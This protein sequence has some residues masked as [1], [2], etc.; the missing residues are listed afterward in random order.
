MMYHSNTDGTVS[1]LAGYGGEMPWSI[2]RS[3]LPVFQWQGG[4]LRWGV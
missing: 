2:G 1:E 3:E 4:S